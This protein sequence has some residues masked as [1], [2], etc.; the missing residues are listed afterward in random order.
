[1]EGGEIKGQE[2]S[3]DAHCELHLGGQQFVDI[4]SD[5]QWHAQEGGP[6]EG[7]GGA[8]FFVVGFVRIGMLTDTLAEAPWA[9]AASARLY[10]YSEYR[11]C[12]KT[13]E[14]EAALY[15]KKGTA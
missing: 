7:H 11:M 2:N 3:E 1:V 10:P 13:A 4:V 9:I 14:S 15:F 12:A 8:C 6:A 5:F